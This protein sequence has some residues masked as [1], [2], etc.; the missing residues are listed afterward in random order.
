MREIIVKVSHHQTDLSKIRVIDFDFVCW[1]WRVELKFFKI[2]Q[3]HSTNKLFN[4]I[5]NSLHSTRKKTGLISFLICSL[6]FYSSFKFCLL[7]GV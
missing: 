3:Q 5:E 1:L 2:F 4:F 7:F 6:F